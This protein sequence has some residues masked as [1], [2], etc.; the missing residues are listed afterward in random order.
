[1]AHAKSLKETARETSAEDHG[2]VGT[3]ARD[4]SDACHSEA[5]IGSENEG[6]VLRGDGS[7]RLSG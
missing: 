5:P 1:M 3:T 2:E 4:A 7:G 6:A